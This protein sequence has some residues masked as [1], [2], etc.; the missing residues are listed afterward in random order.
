GLLAGLLAG[1]GGAGGT[2]GRGFLNDGGVGGA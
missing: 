2:G 1:P